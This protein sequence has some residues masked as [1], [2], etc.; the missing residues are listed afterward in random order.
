MIYFDQASSSFPKPKMVAEAMVEAVNEYGANPGRGGHRLS[1]KAASVIENTRRKLS[2]MFQSDRADRVIFSSN[3]T[4]A[5][6]QGIFGLSLAEGDHV[7]TTS[8][9]HNSVRRPLEKLKAEKGIRVTY[10]QPSIS[11]EEAK[12]SLNNALTE[13]TKLVVMTHGSNLTGEVLPIEEW[14]D[15]LK[16]HNA[17][18]FVDASQTAGVLPIKMIDSGIDMLAFPSHK[19]LLG[20][21]GVGVLI[22]QLH[23]RLSPRIVGGTGS[24]SESKEQPDIWPAGLESGTLNTPGIAGLLKGL[25]YV[26]KESLEK[27]YAHEKHLTDLCKKGLMEMGEVEVIAPRNEV[28]QLGVVAFR[29]PGIDVNEM[30]MILDEHY[31]IAVRSGLHCTPLAHQTC[32]TIDTGLIRVS[33]GP[34]NTEQEVEQLIVAI[35]EIKEGLL[36]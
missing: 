36:S 27:I 5:I 3:A 35:Q 13:R 2:I 10:L 16:D 29:I 20:P 31:G 1:Q 7:I 33:F 34:F 19:G 11:K 24:H 32:N 30:A 26:E 9:E 15:V 12:Q 22:V 28:K 18:F 25:E 4:T 14:G 21:Q 23:V 8:F 6:N 17:L